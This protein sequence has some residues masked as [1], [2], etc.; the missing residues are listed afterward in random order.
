MQVKAGAKEVVWKTLLKI[1]LV[2]C[3]CAEYAEKKN[4][5]FLDIYNEANYN[6]GR[7]KKF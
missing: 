7:R 4:A 1:P 3:P 6:G 5:I 2:W